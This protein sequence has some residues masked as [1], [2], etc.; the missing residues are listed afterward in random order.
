MLVIH[1]GKHLPLALSFNVKVRRFSLIK[2]GR[3]SLMAVRYFQKI[4]AVMHDE[5]VLT[6]ISTTMA[7]LALFFVLFFV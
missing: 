4:A 5:P 6:Q 3:S 1:L 7:A 2:G